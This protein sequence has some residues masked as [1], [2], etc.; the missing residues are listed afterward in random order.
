MKGVSGV[1]SIQVDLKKEEGEKIE[2]STF[3]LFLYYLILGEIIYENPPLTGDKVVQE[4]DD[5]G[6][7]VSLVSDEGTVV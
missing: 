6:F 4:I 7:E 3:I 2:R 5:C 1:I